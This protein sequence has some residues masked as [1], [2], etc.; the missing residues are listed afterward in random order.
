MHENAKLICPDKPTSEDVK[1]LSQK[2]KEY[3][4][5]DTK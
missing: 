5:C 2:L 3:K 4:K 1:E